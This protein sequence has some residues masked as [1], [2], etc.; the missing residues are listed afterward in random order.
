MLISGIRAVLRNLSIIFLPR[1]KIIRIVPGKFDARYKIYNTFT[2]IEIPIS[3]LITF[4]E[5]GNIIGI[6]DSTFFSQAKLLMNHKKLAI[7]EDYSRELKTRYPEIDLK[8]E[9]ETFL[10]TYLYVSNHILDQQ[11]LVRKREIFG[12]EFEVIDGM[13]RVSILLALGESKIRCAVTK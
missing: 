1:A 8:A 5:S 7:C 12:A 6:Q 3:D 2:E 13:H 4:D 10:Q 9:I 11:I